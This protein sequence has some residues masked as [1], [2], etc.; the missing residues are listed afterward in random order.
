MSRF[1]SKPLA[2]VEISLAALRHNLRQI[3]KKIGPRAEVMAIVKAD[4]YGHG[5]RAVAL[6]LHRRGV[7][8]FGVASIQEARELLGFLPRAKVLVLGSFHRDQIA[9]FVAFGVRPTLSS[10]ED[11]RLFAREA[12]LAGKKRFPVHVKIDTGMGRLG[13]WHEEAGDLFQ[14]LEGASTLEVEG[15]YTHFASADSSPAATALQIARFNRAVTR[16]R[17]AGLR[18]RYRHAANSMAVARFRRAHLN[19]VRPGIALYGLDPAGKGRPPMGLKPVLSLKARITFVKETPRG[20][21]VSYGSTFRAS[22]DTRIAALAVGYSHGYRIGLSNQAAVLVRG[23][24]CPVAGRVTMDQTLVDIG[25]VPEAKRWDIA[26]L[27][28]GA[29]GNRIGAE[30]LSRILHTIPYEI[31]CGISARV[32]RFSIKV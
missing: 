4:A 8:F 6:E 32:P 26:T 19:L 30:E 7:R 11:V 22:C 31:V 18:P 13:V 29:S 25:H 24:R 3:R 17:A 5:M 27:I 9:E 14:Q 10:P 12:R 16:A 23:R 2:W 28:G 1:P 15:I 21:A 20:R